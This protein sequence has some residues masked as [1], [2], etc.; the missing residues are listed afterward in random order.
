MNNYSQ[1]PN[2]RTGM[3]KF[4]RYCEPRRFHITGRRELI[5][6][7][8]DWKFFKDKLWYHQHDNLSLTKTP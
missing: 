4:H 8:N 2:E 5:Q 3:K 6:P 7:L 1:L